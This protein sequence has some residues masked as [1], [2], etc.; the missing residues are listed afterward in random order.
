MDYKR[1]HYT[2]NFQFGTCVVMIEKKEYTSHTINYFTIA[3]PTINNY[4]T[5]YV[6]LSYRY[7]HF[8]ILTDII[9]INNEIS[10][11]DLL[12]WTYTTCDGPRKLFRKEEGMLRI[13]IHW[14]FVIYR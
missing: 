5:M 6:N 11:M 1:E 4:Q 9:H 2:T 7:C 10:S 8:C 3:R 14:L 12:M 13:Q